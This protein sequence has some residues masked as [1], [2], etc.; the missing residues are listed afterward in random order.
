MAQKE[1][2]LILPL[3]LY[4]LGISDLVNSWR[5][6]LKPEQRYLPYTLTSILLLDTAFWNFFQLYDWIQEDHFRSYLTYMRILAAPLLFVLV[7]A[8]FTP[9]EGTGSLK[10]YFHQHMRTVFALLALF[11]F[12]HFLLDPNEFVWQRLGAIAM[13]LTTAFFRKTWLIYLLLGFRVLTLAFDF[14]RIDT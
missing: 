12:V 6:F 11:V 5:S 2:Y 7:V 1:Y 4:G 14:G 13:L 8:I 10:E 3:L 9:E